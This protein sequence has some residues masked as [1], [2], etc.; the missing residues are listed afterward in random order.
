MSQLAYT[1]EILVKK[2]G[3][4]EVLIIQKGIKICFVFL[5]RIIY[6]I[7]NVCVCR[8]IPT[9]KKLFLKIQFQHRKANPKNFP[10]VDFILLRGDNFL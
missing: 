7:M 8:I 10:L 9:Y 2:D 3:A 5:G 6:L 1:I 4:V